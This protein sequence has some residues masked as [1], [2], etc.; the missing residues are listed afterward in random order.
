MCGHH[1]WLVEAIWSGGTCCTVAAITCQVV[2]FVAM[3]SAGSST[4]GAGAGA[5]S[6]EGFEVAFNVDHLL[7]PSTTKRHRAGV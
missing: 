3:E 6:R 1:G 2:P 7:H 4:N 5:G